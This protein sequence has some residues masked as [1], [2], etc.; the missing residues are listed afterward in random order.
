MLFLDEEPRL[1][2]LLRNAKHGTWG[3]PKGHRE[4]GESL[5]ECAARETRE[6]TGGLGWEAVSGF[7]ESLRYYA[8]VERRDGPGRGYEKEVHY[9]LGRAE[10]RDFERSAEHSE[11]RWVRFEEALELLQHPQ[12]RDLLR[13][14]EQFLD[15]TVTG[16]GRKG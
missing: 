3:F 15:G 13:S 10:G 9:F 6:E 14:A 11:A 1:W 8:D 16:D 12:S 2:L 7:R 5:E 4:E